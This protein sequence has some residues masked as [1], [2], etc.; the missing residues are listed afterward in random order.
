M[1]STKQEIYKNLR[2]RII[3]QELQP[4][5][6]LNE[7]ELMAHYSIG[8]T[9]MREVLLELKNDGLVQIIPRSG[10]LV[11][12]LDLHELKQVIEVRTNLEGLV[13]EL[14]ATRITDD[15]L[16]Q[17]REILRKVDE[18]LAIDTVNSE[19]LFQL[20]SDFHGVVYEAAQN[21]KLMGI[22]Q[23]LQG[24][25]ARY[26]YYLVFGEKELLAQI[27]DQREIFQAL[28]QRDPVASKRIMRAHMQNFNN[29]VKDRIL[30]S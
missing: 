9:P 11:A 5:Q 1:I 28:E 13:G 18:H 4:G 26:W 27:D 23:E 29:Q 7:K 20:E 15:Q 10:T 24:V 2:Y 25:C 19:H 6:V 30:G 16:E 22:L 14:A 17:L 3:T 12:P 21:K 8:R